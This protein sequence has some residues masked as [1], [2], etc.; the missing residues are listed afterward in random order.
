MSQLRQLHF[1]HRN[2][3][4]YSCQTDS[5]QKLLNNNWLMVHFSLAVVTQTSI[6]AYAQSSQRCDRNPR[7][8]DTDNLNL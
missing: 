2:A 6:A 7:D 1:V 3:A 5:R 8:T 4:V